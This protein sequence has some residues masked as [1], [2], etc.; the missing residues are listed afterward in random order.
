M[1]IAVL[2]AGPLASGAGQE[3][4]APDAIARQVRACLH[5]HYANQDRLAMVDRVFG[6][7]ERLGAY[8]AAR[9]RAE[10]VARL[11]ADL[12]VATGDAGVRVDEGKVASAGDVGAYALG[13]GLHL[14]V[15]ATRR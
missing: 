15:P 13:E 4:A 6:I 10:L 1:A 5:D 3:H 11:N 7:E 12:R 9:T 2:G 14:V 8:R